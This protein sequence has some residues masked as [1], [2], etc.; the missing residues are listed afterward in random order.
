MFLLPLLIFPILLAAAVYRLYKL[1]RMYMSGHLQLAHGVW[2]LTSILTGIAYIGLLA[3]TIAL[4]VLTVRILLN[5]NAA[6]A[7][8]LSIAPAFAGYPVMYIAAEW[9]FYYGFL[10]PEK[11]AR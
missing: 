5:S 3:Y 7:D 6:L 11:R 4:A 8:W 1:P 9:T 10:R 2:S